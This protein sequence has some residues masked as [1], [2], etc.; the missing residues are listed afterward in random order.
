MGID[1]QH[2]DGFKTHLAEH[3][4]GLQANRLD[5]NVDSMLIFAAKNRLFSPLGNISD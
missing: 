2:W 5:I 4:L 3:F 1:S